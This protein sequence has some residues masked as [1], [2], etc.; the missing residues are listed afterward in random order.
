MQQEG[1]IQGWLDTIDQKKKIIKDKDKRC[2]QLESE[3]GALASKNS[4][5]NQTIKKLE[6]QLAESASKL[7]DK[8]GEIIGLKRL[9]DTVNA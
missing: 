1:A 7:R 4:G 9:N 5:L 8:E 3:N 6:M 2:D